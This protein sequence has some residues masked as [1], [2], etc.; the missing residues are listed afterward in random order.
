MDATTSVLNFLA[1]VRGRLLMR[2]VA[3]GIVSF[4]L[5]VLVVVW[6]SSAITWLGTE[7]AWTR[8]AAGLL[9]L[10]ILSFLTWMHLLRPWWQTRDP[11]IVAAVVDARLMDGHSGVS[12]T[13]DLGMLSSGDPRLA[14]LSRTLVQRVAG[15][16][17]E[18]LQ[19]LDPGGFVDHG[20]VQQRAHQLLLAL[21][22]AL[23]S[24]AILPG[25]LLDGGRTF[26]GW[27]TPG[28]AS[29][30]IDELRDVL[31]RDIHYRLVFPAYT[32]APDRRVE[33]SAGDIQAVRGTLVTLEASPVFAP[34]AAQ[35]LLEDGQR[36]PLTVTEKGMVQGQLTV[37]ESTA[38]RFELQNAGG[39]WVRER[40]SHSL[41]ATED[42][43]PLVVLHTPDS[44]MEVHA[45]D[46]V[47]LAFDARDDHGIDRLHHVLR[48]RR[49]G[50]EART[51]IRRLAGEKT[52]RGQAVVD[53]ASFQFKPG[54]LVELW[55]EATDENT[56]S[57]PGIGRSESRKLKI[58]SPQEKHNELVEA[59]ALLID[60]FLDILADRL[61]SALHPARPFQFAAGRATSSQ[62]NAASTTL[63]DGFEAVIKGIE[64]DPLMPAAILTDL[65]Q[66]LERHRSR[67]QSER[68]ALK[69][70]TL[71][72]S[73]HSDHIRLLHKHNQDHI[74]ILEEDIW[75]LDKLV[76]RLREQKLLDQ[77]RDLVSQQADLMELLENLQREGSASDTDAA[78]AMLDQLQNQLDSMMR[79]LMAQA[80]D[81]PYE[82]FNPGALDP[83]GTHQ[84]ISD[85]RS[86][87]D[88]IR[89]KL[90][91]GDVEGAMALAQELQQQMASMMATMEEG[92][93]GFPLAGA[94]PET[95]R[96]LSKLES[97]VDELA[98]EEGS[99][100]QETTEI[101]TSLEK[102]LDSL[103]K[104]GVERMQKMTREKLE[105]ITDQLA[106]VPPDTLSPRDERRLDSARRTMEQ[107]HKAVDE[108]RFES[109]QPFAES[110]AEGCREVGQ[111][112]Q[113]VSH[114]ATDPQRAEEFENAGELA[115]K[116]GETARELAE[117]LK[118]QV[119]D[120]RDLLTPQEKKK[121]ARLGK[122]QTSAGKK[123]E[124]LIRK[125]SK[126]DAIP[127]S[128]RD[129]FAEE[130]GAAGEHMD[131]AYKQ[132]QESSPEQAAI[133]EQAALDRLSRAQ[134]RILQMMKPSKSGVGMGTGLAQDDIAIP[135]AEDYSVPRK[136]R[137][138]VMKAMQ[139]NSP[140]EYKSRV[141]DYYEE[142]VR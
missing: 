17:S 38:Y 71:E 113:D 66:I 91:A 32:R 43:P 60:R 100:L 132:L 103:L 117:E 20:A 141:E 129:R 35:L 125:L 8:M 40:R 127:Q 81:L 25:P 115:L 112:L 108:E 114:R 10:T 93:E 122:D 128:L 7:V 28:E 82:N 89:E 26:L 12:T 67:I 44:D 50:E 68:H 9:L 34:K 36:I 13:V 18:R 6:I 77:T 54:D 15:E 70:V 46:R 138:T 4:G 69:V 65:Q 109:I 137:E 19:G 85:L 139:E 80:K 31:A 104:T 72:T 63:L 96:A 107:A 119:P 14:G 102:A 58:W 106:E 116:A 55:V 45:Q 135:Q 140:R 51:P 74:L 79:D 5:A 101:S 83:Q 39:D 75:T 142:L 57:G 120:P 73:I 95:T 33:G 94:D 84:S 105:E 64:E 121:L 133:E 97:S 78:V 27:S 98:K 1:R 118:Q 90:A 130:L 21:L 126:E 56:V 24:T 124:R 3:E 30:D 86:Q 136:L 92:L 110:I 37:T 49:T 11:Q 87:M 53:L 2:S 23:A 48:N 47:E 134:K 22:L 76:D 62:V 42:I 131:N 16:T 59:L 61:E 52:H 99:L 41:D 123:L 111:N 88:A 29:L